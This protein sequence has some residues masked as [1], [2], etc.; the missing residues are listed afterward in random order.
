M[1]ESITTLTAPISLSTYHQLSLTGTYI[2]LYC[3]VVNNDEYPF[4]GNKTYI[5][6]FYFFESELLVVTGNI[7]CTYI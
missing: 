6:L 5:T 2:E 1:T 4:K 3:Y 7:Y